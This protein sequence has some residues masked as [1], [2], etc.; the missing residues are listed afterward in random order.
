MWFEYGYIHFDDVI[1]AAFGGYIY[2][3][4]TFLKVKVNIFFVLF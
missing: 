2:S 1:T 3:P 4:N